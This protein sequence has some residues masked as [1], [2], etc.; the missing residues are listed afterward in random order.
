MQHVFEVVMGFG[1][2]FVVW[3]VLSNLADDIEENA[4]RDLPKV[5]KE[6]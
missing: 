2:L 6:S 3:W 1:Y 5:N 4:P